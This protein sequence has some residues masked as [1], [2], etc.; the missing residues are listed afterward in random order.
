MLF[1]FALRCRVRGVVVCV[2]VCVCE[3]GSHFVSLCL[4]LTSL[5]IRPRCSLICASVSVFACINSH[6]FAVWVSG[7]AVVCL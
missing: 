7:C 5:H 2:Y 1:P 3:G 6:V 4:F